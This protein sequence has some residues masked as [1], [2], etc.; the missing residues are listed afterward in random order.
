M[1][2]SL[3]A[4]FFGFLLLVGLAVTGSAGPLSGGAD[5][6]MDGVADAFDNCIEVANADQ[7]DP[8]HDGC[9]T[10]CTFGASIAC[11]ITGDGKVGAPDFSAL[12]SEIGNSA[13][14]SGITNAQCDPTSCGCTPS[15]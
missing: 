8:D 7:A 4:M 3:M 6:D 15:A 5:T 9:G 2:I 10:A 13:G 14:P 12:V 11:D 1:K